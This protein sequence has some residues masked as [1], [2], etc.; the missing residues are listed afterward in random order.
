MEPDNFLN[1]N[2]SFGADEGP[3]AILTQTQYIQDWNKVDQNVS[4]LIWHVFKE[5]KEDENYSL[6]IW[7]I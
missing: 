1:A 2:C 3:S 5:M 7:H 6:L 4:L